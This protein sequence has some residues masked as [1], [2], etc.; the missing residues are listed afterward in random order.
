MRFVRRLSRNGNSMTVSLDPRLIAWLQWTPQQEL[1][2][3]ATLDRKVLI[4]LRRPEEINAP[5]LPMTL[6]LTAPGSTR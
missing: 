3:E 1:V 5:G 2:V 4:S 6:D